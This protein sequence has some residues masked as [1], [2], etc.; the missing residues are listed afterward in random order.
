M[1]LERAMKT[2]ISCE[3]DKE[4]VVSIKAVTKITLTFHIFLFCHDYCYHIK[5]NLNIY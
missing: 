1:V 4:S 3:D 5:I 2:F